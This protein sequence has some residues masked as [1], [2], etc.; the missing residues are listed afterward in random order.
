MLTPVEPEAATPSSRDVSG[1]HNTP[2]GTAMLVVDRGPHRG[3]QIR[4]NQSRIQIGR[5]PNSDIVL[6]DVTVSRRHALIEQESGQ[7]V[8]TDSGSLN[9]TYVNRRP[10]DQKVVLN[11]GDELRIGI[12]RLIFHT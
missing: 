2:R 9:G 4:L 5:G 3:Q 10:V 12:F 8:I 11:E 7:Y 1:E 6:E